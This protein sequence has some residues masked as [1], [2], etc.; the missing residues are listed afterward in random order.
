MK[1]GIDPESFGFLVND[2]ARL[3]RAE[4]D[5]RIAASGLGLTPGEARVLAYAARFEPVRQS[6]LAER[7]ALEP[8]TVSTYL[9][10]LEA[11]G[12]V[13]RQTDPADRRAKLVT[14][15]A[16]APAVLDGIG[17][18]AADIRALAASPIGQDRWDE[19]KALLVAVRDG[20]QGGAGT[21]SD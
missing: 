1:R 9:D 17:A 3:V 12:L 19:L 8:M 20:L 21:D 11:R 14:L 7:A 18:I 16:A 2:V 5:R 6:V 4:M 15:T 13:E 10:A